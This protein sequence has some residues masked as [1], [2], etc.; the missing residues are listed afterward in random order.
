MSIFLVEDPNS[1]SKHRESV[2]D[3]NFVAAQFFSK[4]LSLLGTHRP[5]QPVT[6]I[7]DRNEFAKSHLVLDDVHYDKD[8]E[9]PYFHS[10]SRRKKRYLPPASQGHAHF[11]NMVNEM[12]AAAADQNQPNVHFTSLTADQIRDTPFREVIEH[13]VADERGPFNVPLYLRAEIQR[14]HVSRL[15][16]NMPSHIRTFIRRSGQIIM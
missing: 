15:R 12:R 16:P 14:T 3:V 9:I 11:D 1:G 6:H 8:S 2:Y 13:V 7:V 5:V 10:E 4:R